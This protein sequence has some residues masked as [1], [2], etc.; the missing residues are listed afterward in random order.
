MATSI[1][2]KPTFRRMKAREPMVE[3]DIHSAKAVTLRRF[4]ETQN[5]GTTI[6]KHVLESLDS[7]RPRPTVGHMPIPSQAVNDFN[8]DQMQGISRPQTPTPKKCRVSI[9]DRV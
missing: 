8:D 3:G 2:K 5:D 4:A 6:I 9:I 1:K 7:S